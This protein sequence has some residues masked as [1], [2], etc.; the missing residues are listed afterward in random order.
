MSAAIK[1]SLF[2]S[3]LSLDNKAAKIVYVELYSKV[4]IE[5]QYNTFCHSI[6]TLH[7]YIYIHIFIFFAFYLRFFTGTQSYCL[8]RHLMEKMHLNKN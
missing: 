3:F 4:Y 1:V 8:R 2:I 7:T 6:S 5:S